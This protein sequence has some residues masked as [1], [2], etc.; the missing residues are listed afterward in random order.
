MLPRSQHS[1]DLRVVDLD[2]RPVCQ[3]AVADVDSGGLTR[4]ACVLLEGKPQDGN[5]LALDGV[6]HGGDHAL[7][8]NQGVEWGDGGRKEGE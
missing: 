7:Q 1:R 6:E 8:G 5:L 2:E 4:V 3:Q